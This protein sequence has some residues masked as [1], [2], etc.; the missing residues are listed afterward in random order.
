[1]TLIDGA[2]AFLHLRS[3]FM[4]EPLLSAIWSLCASAGEVDA[5]SRDRLAR[6]FEGWLA[7]SHEGVA[8][9]TCHRVELYGLGHVPDL[10]APRVRSNEIAVLHL[11]RVA[12][13]LESV[14]VGEDEV[15][16]QVREALNR[17]QLSGRL[18]FRLRRLFETAIATGRRARSGRT[19]PGG[20][21]A[22]RAAAWLC[23]RSQLAGR[24]VVIAGAGHMGAALAHALAGAG[25]AI[26]IASR[27]PRRASRLAA[28][29]GGDGVD[30]TTGAGLTRQAVAVAV[31][32]GG[33][34]TELV[35]AGGHE[36]P[37]IADISAPQAVP[38]AVR[39]RLN[40]S[41]L[42]ID[43][44]YRRRESVPGPY[45]RDAEALIDLK[46]GEYMSWLARRTD[47]EWTETSVAAAQ[48]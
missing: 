8:L 33:P 44:L 20:N 25:A 12:A 11:L 26:T 46:A 10:T 40:G 34:W 42:G 1:M 16:H 28:V 6:E 13:G 38:D 36:L 7:N 45:V 35:T 18:D 27:D 4:R 17:A 5:A 43:D 29:Y 15:L 2:D 19:E 14:I 23:T 24:P 21:L 30:L 32:L 3:N 9:K 48:F 41:F 22:Q 47:E 37:P 39:R 31:A